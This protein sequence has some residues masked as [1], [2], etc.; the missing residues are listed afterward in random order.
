M[1]SVS[2][3][4]NDKFMNKKRCSWCEG[5]PIYESYH[6]KE[7]GVPVREDAT[8]FEFLILEGFQ[9]GLSWITILKKREAF[10]KAFDGFDYHKISAYGQNKLDQLALDASIVRN[11]LKIKAAVQNAQAFIRIQE[12]FGSFSAYYWGF[13]N[14]QSLI[15][16]VAVYKEAAAHTPLS[17]R[18][19]KDLKRRGFNFV[20]PTIVYAFMQATGMV[21]D[22]EEDCFKKT[23]KKPQKNPLKIGL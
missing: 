15:N 7:W 19:S 1:F 11:K 3:K 13:T 2:L 8:L 5:D 4:I 22:H 18:L 21:D 20:G 17:N 6:D 12:E 9:A 23:T 10:R 16:K 14:G